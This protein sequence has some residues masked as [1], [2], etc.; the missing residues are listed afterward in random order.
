[1]GRR[2]RSDIQIAG[3]GATPSYLCPG[4]VCNPGIA[5]FTAPVTASFDQRHK[6]DSFGTLR[7]RFGTTITPDVMVYATGGL[8][9]GSI[10]S[11]V[12][13]AGVGFDADGN[14]GPH[15]H[16]GADG[17]G[18]AGP[19]DRAAGGHADPHPAPDAG[20]DQLAHSDPDGDADPRA[21]DPDA[22]SGQRVG[23]RS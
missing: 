22:R 23:P 19:D 4:A 20:A 3:Q 13:L 1:M 6:L 9:V 11:T 7:G 16:A 12:R 2:H 10:R 8:A 14:P 5:D 15:R 21:A 17:N 18:D